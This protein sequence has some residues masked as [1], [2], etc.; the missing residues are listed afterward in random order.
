MQRVA[1]GKH[2]YSPTGHRH[3]TQL[4]AVTTHVCMHLSCLPLMIS[5]E[6]TVF[7]KL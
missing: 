2:T 1:H 5:A 3:F 4:Y 7:F 6:P